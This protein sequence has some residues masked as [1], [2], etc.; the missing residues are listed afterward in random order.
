[1]TLEEE[2]NCLRYEGFIF[3]VI[4]DIWWQQEERT[5][6]LFARRKGVPDPHPE[7]PWMTGPSQCS[8]LSLRSR[9]W[10]RPVLAT[11]P[12]ALSALRSLGGATG[13]SSRP[14]VRSQTGRTRLGAA[15]FSGFAHRVGGVSSS[16]F[17][18]PKAKLVCSPSG[19]APVPGGVPGAA[20]PLQAGRGPPPLFGPRH[21]PASEPAEILNCFSNGKKVSPLQSR[22]LSCH[23]P[24]CITICTSPTSSAMSTWLLDPLGSPLAA[25]QHPPRSQVLSPGLLRGAGV[26]WILGPSPHLGFLPLPGSGGSGIKP[27]VAPFLPSAH[28]VAFSCLQGRQD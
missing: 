1:M 17:S 6:G 18:P 22:W 14:E 16:A 19:S 8:R 5:G 10:F 4:A 13:T 7:A 21:L 26:G 20:C 24:D 25:P 28:W 27:S 3:E 9:D 12:R 11:L 2:I 23:L 15:E